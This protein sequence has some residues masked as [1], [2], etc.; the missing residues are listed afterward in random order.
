MG[1]EADDLM[2]GY[3]LTAEEKGDY[4]VV[5]TKFDG[6]FSPQCHM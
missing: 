2:T 3:G 1:D 5:K 6:H 4:D